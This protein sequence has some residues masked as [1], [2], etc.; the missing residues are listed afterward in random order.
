MFA[1]LAA[2][3][4]QV[5]APPPGR[6]TEAQMRRDNDIWAQCLIEAALREEPSER[7]VETVADSAL[8]ACS[9]PEAAFWRSW[10]AHMEASGV[11]G[12]QQRQMRTMMVAEMR[13]GIANVVRQNRPAYLF[14][15][16]QQQI[17]ARRALEADI[18]RALADD[19]QRRQRA[20]LTAVDNL[21]GTCWNQVTA[22]HARTA[23][24]PDAV[25][26]LARQRCAPYRAELRELFKLGLAIGGRQPSD[27]RADF[28]VNLIE[29]RLA[30]RLLRG[31]ANIRRDQP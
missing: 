19:A 16:L 4:L 20:L 11:N 31:V 7:P 18:E 5:T 10:Q 6:P 30:E 27:E 26:S 25:V 29:E 28:E 9:T 8:A 1:F 12:E 24:A 13:P 3:A 2:V 17:E 22:A 21:A 14:A 23:T 15:Q